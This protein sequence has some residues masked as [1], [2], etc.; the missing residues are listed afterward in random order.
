MKVLL[1]LLLISAVAALPFEIRDPTRDPALEQPE[2]TFARSDVDKDDKLTFNQFL[3]TDLPY[4]QLKKEEFNNLDIDHDGFVTKTE[5]E[6]HYQKEK[7]SAYDLKAE[8]FG[9]LYDQFDENMDLKLDIN[10]IKNVLEKRFLLKPRENFSQIFKG[11]DKNNDGA[12]DLEEYI[13][14]DAE[15]PF[16]ELDPLD[17]AEKVPQKSDHI[18]FKKEK[19]PMM[20]NN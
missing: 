12:L 1:C 9:Q 15:F 4:V 16:Q 11:F 19:L 18:E 5:Y 3:L 14:F 8:Y 10:E 6:Q 7:E 17:A 20:K 13:K 2:E